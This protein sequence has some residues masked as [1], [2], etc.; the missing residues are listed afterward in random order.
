[1]QLST[2]LCTCCC[3]FM[4]VLDMI[5]FYGAGLPHRTG[6]FFVQSFSWALRFSR[7]LKVF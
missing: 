5:Q 4:Y 6:S 2:L 7:V 1:M 3:L